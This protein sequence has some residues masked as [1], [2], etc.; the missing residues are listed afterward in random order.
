M[1]R[2][3]A[4]GGLCLAGSLVSVCALALLAGC[5]TAAFRPTVR[6]AMPTVA[7][8]GRTLAA[9]GGGYAALRDIGYVAGPAVCGLA[10]LTFGLSAAFA[11]NSGRGAVRAARGARRDRRRGPPTCRELPW[12]SGL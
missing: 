1:V 2:A 9:L 3:G 6:A 7:R 4:Y 10:V 5:A 12:P 8:D 11:L